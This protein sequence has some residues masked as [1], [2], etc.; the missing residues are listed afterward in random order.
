MASKRSCAFC[1]RQDELTNEHAWPDWISGVVPD[2]PGSEIYVRHDDRRTGDTGSRR[3]SSPPFSS[4]VKRVC[5]PCNNGWMSDLEGAAKPLLTPMLTG[6]SIV[7][8]PSDQATIALW[9]VKTALMHQWTN[10][11]GRSIP[12]VFY[13]A[14]YATRRPPVGTGVYLG[15]APQ[16]RPVA[17]YSHGA[18]GI[19][20][21]RQDSLPDTYRI[22]LLAGDLVIDIAGYLD[23]DRGRNPGVSRSD[24]KFVRTVWP[25]SGTVRWP[26]PVRLS[27]RDLRGMRLAL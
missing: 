14:V 15:R 18:L 5:K 17:A 27:P 8:S 24:Q 9:A 26:P 16:N 10:P 1:G 22:A 7:L 6:R 2:K 23:P 11:S 20:E 21:P 13:H 19:G 4:T 3:Y 12:D 25:V